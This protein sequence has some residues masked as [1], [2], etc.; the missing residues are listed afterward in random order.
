MYDKDFCLFYFL[1]L[2]T[3]F[4]IIEADI[5]IKTKGFIPGQR[6]AIRLGC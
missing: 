6:L 3:I 2:I 4:F 1:S 5:L